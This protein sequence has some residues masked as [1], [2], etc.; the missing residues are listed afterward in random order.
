MKEIQD[1]PQYSIFQLFHILWECYDCVRYYLLWGNE[2]YFY[3]LSC[4][5]EICFQ[6]RNNALPDFYFVCNK[7]KQQVEHFSLEFSEEN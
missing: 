5:R 1:L 7:I 6:K 3:Y 2:I 4:C